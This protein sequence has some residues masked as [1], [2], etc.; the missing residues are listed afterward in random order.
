M[1][2]RIASPI[3]IKSCENPA[4][5]NTFPYRSNRRSCSK[6]CRKILSRS[7]FISDKEVS[8]VLSKDRDTLDTFDLAMRLGSQYYTI[9]PSKRED[10]LRLCIAT[11]P[12][13]LRL[14]RAL[15]CP[16]LIKPD[17]GKRSLFHRRSPESYRTMAEIANT[18]CWHVFGIS[19]CQ[20]AKNPRNFE[21]IP[22][23]N[24][25][26]NFDV[27]FVYSKKPAKVFDYDTLISM[28]SNRPSD[29]IN[30]TAALLR[31]RPEYS[32]G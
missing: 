7:S 6:A 30:Y 8:A 24:D 19:V 11:V 1:P 16:G 13:S 14:R 23:V 18:Y 3:T 12:H 17:R 10:F 22:Y 21:G 32:L 5:T 28:M 25:L 15:T 20:Y 2:T 4:C 26:S 31:L 29:I 27:P 9:E